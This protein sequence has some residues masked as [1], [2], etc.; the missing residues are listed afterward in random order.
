M[1]HI[2]KCIFWG[3]KKGFRIICES[4]PEDSIKAEVT[5][6]F[7]DVREFFV[8]HKPYVDFYSI[9][10]F[11]NCVGYTCHRSSKDLGRDGF[12]AVTVLTDY[13]IKVPNIQN[14][15]KE[16]LDCYFINY[17]NP[18]TW[19]PSSR[20][21]EDIRLFEA[22]LDKYE[23][24]LENPNHVLR[25]SGIHKFIIY[26]DESELDEY[27]DNPY[28]AQFTQC[29]KIFL[30]SK[31]IYENPADCQIE[32]TT[33]PILI[34]VEDKGR[35]VGGVGPKATTNGDSSDRVEED[36]ANG[37]SRKITVDDNKAELSDLKHNV[38]L[39]LKKNVG[40]KQERLVTFINCRNF[41]FVTR[42]GLRDIKYQVCQVSSMSDEILLWDKRG[43]QVVCRIE[44]G[45]NRNCN[46][47]KYTD[48]FIVRWKDDNHCEVEYRKVYKLSLKKLIRIAAVI[49]SL[50]I[51]GSIAFFYHHME[52]PSSVESVQVGLLEEPNGDTKNLP[53]EAQGQLASEK[54]I[55]VNGSSIESTDGDIVSRDF[56]DSKLNRLVVNKRIAEEVFEKAKK[57]DD[58]KLIARAN[59][60][61]WFFN[62][63]SLDDVKNAVPYFTKAQ[64]QICYATYLKSPIYFKKTKD[65]CGM[66]FKLAQK[67]MED[68]SGE[69]VNNNKER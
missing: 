8:F 16:L 15:L 21:S 54:T 37:R 30:L 25:P 58:V 50:V 5:R 44:V 28:N 42:K 3:C 14:L 62:A 56:L 24:R 19:E 64:K 12:V 34:G 45:I 40:V 32:F 33:P 39:A 6:K 17:V 52:N 18:L 57:I 43:N 68:V 1:P 29:Q 55:D 26:N 20:K 31:T 11:E 63:Q 35:E 36:S 47:D 67:F 53:Y 59:A 41:K 23:T 60:Y 38:N 22:I 2:Y 69:Q 9:E 13:I 65:N 66:N 49:A 46:K 48:E 51:M 7:T 10:F 61:L 4:N 27:L